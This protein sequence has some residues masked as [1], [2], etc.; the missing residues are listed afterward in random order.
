MITVLTASP[1]NDPE[2]APIPSVTN[3]NQN[4]CKLDTR[5][6]PSVTTSMNAENVPSKKKLR[7]EDDLTTS[8]TTM[9]VNTLTPKKDE[10]L[11]FVDNILDTTI[12]MEDIGIDMENVQSFNSDDEF[13]ME[14]WSVSKAQNWPF[15]PLTDSS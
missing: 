14:V 12:E 13:S 10:H 6:T 2:D 9:P 1:V 8:A 11:Q 5:L 3:S 15:N 7:F 4:N